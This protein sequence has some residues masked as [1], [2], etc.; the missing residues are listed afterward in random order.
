MYEQE[1]AKKPKCKFE[2]LSLVLLINVYDI[3]WFIAL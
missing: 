2:L 3:K 1:Y